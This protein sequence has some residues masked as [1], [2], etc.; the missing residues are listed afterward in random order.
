MPKRNKRAEQ[1]DARE[2][3]HCYSAGDYYVPVPVGM[4]YLISYP[5]NMMVCPACYQVW[6]EMYPD[7]A[8][9][10]R[11][12][13]KAKSDGAKKKKALQELQADQPNLL[14]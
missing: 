8:K 11:K 12:I 4:G 1:C 5:R 7:R 3:I 6:C 13:A 9:A 14:D 10:K 2:S